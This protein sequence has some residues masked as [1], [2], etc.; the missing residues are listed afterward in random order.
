MYDDDG[1]EIFETKGAQDSR[2]EKDCE[3]HTIRLA[4]NEVIVAV[5]GDHS[6][7]YKGREGHW[8]NPEFLIA[9]R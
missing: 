9:S 2:W 8:K 7:V 4:P 5:R 1:D 6:D 3:K